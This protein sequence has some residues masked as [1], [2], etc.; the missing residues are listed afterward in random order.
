MPVN[1]LREKQ[2]EDC[3]IWNNDRRH[4]RDRPEVE[5]LILSF[6]E[7]PR[8]PSEDG[9]DRLDVGSRL[10]VGLILLLLLLGLLLPGGGV[11]TN[12]G[13]QDL[14]DWPVVALRIPRDPFEGVDRA[15]ADFE[16]L[17]VVELVDCLGE[18]LGDLPLSAQVQLLPARL[19]IVL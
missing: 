1:K 11:L 6:P 12:V 16:R 10:R 4:A 5:R 17:R 19:Q 2:D 13:G 3:S 15:H 14:H 7:G 9:Q 8:A 18:A